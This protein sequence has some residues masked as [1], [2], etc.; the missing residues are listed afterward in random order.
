M[1]NL[2][3]Y[4]RKKLLENK[5]VEK[6]TEKSVVYTSKFKQKALESYL[7]GENAKDIFLRAGIPVHY[8]DNSKYC[9]SCLKRWKIK[10]EQEGAGCFDN[11]LRG[12]GATGRPKTEN[13]DEL[14]YEELQA[15]VEVQRGVIQELK[16][17]KALAKKK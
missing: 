3:S 7:A 2:S 9:Q 4:Q 16:K 8:F 5:N 15:I 12:V 13:L 1:H 11:D 10:F 17:K 14:T 6:L